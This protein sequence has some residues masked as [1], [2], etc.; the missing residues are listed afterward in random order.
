MER[1]LAAILAIDM[2]GYSRLMET[3]E[4]G[5]IARQ[6]AHREN[7][8]D[9]QID[10]YTGR[11]VKTTGDGLLAEFPSVVDAVDCALAF[12]SALSDEEQNISEEQRIL[13]RAGI[14][15]GDIVIDGEDILGDGVNVAARLEAI[16]PPGGLCVSDMVRQNLRGAV[17]ESFE[18]IGEQSLKNI[19]RKILVW[20][21]PADDAGQTSPSRRST[22]ARKEE[23][24]PAIEVKPFEIL[25]PDPDHLYYAEGFADDIATAVSKLDT[26]R[27]ISAGID[28]GASA[29][30]YRI[31]GGIRV[32]GPRIR[33]NVQLLDTTDGQ[34]LWAE[35][36]DGLV[37]E[38]FDFQDRITDE[39]VA[40]L[41]VELTEGEQS[42]LWRRESGDRLAYEDF[43]KG[44]AAYKEYSRSGSARARA[45][46]E[47]ALNRSPTFHS[48][49]TALARTHIEDATFG[50]SADRDE[51][52]REA[53]RLLDGVFAIDPHHSWAH[54]DLSHILMVEREF[55][56][57]RL[58]AE[59]AVALDPNSADAHQC[60]AHVL[61][62]LELPEEA[63]RSARR[64]ISLNP[65]TPEFYLMG[66][67]E[68]F[69]ALKR[70]EEAFAVSEQIIVKRPAWITARVL[71]ILALQGLGKEAEAREAVH[72]VL[73]ISPNFTA[74]RWHRIIFYPERP[75]VPD[76]IER[77]VS[78]GLPR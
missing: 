16:A 75:D 72:G 44:R 6:K 29:A 5:T 33:C 60:L 45:A 11:I 18:D 62:C 52:L 77:L 46:Y 78:V 22:V 65:G 30:H 59:L 12:Q 42:K 36:F 76:L 61:V 23:L 13:Y 49:A 2:V 39:V 63:L 56:T 48:A 41:E 69:F 40:G 55:S 7:F 51:S 57:A 66:L 24:P 64:S 15:L 47:S 14:N 9:P 73:E 25:S 21:W 58:E 26:L 37:E 8:I 68:A 19:E 3:D 4:S 53:R 35:K 10:R 74:G 1:R 70:Y 32:S 34:H 67:A 20:R 50:W 71:S 31:E 17:G 43:L 27:V 54:A 28:E 38:I